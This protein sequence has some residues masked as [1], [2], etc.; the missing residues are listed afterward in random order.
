MNC[1]FFVL[2]GCA[3]VELPQET[4][5]HIRDRPRQPE[6]PGNSGP[7]GG[8][9]GNLFS[10]RHRNLRH[11]VGKSS[12]RGA[13][14]RRSRPSLPERVPAIAEPGSPAGPIAR[15][16]AADLAPGRINS[17]NM[18]RRQP[19]G[20]NSAVDDA[21]SVRRPIPYRSGEKPYPATQRGSAAWQSGPDHGISTGRDHSEITRGQRPTHR[22]SGA[23]V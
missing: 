18:H 11:P 9:I 14:R 5:E 8:P 3:T 2:T 12:I 7:G 15:S 6:H 16:L 13:H 20:R 22:N 10:S 21:G 19:H 4:R 23:P 1:R 17:L